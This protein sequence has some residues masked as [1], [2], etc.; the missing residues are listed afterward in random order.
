[1]AFEAAEVFLSSQGAGELSPK[2]FEV[3]DN[4]V[5]ASLR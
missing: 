4:V 5:E 3:G 2:R 1:M